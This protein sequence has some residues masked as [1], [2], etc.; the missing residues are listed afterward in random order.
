MQINRRNILLGSGALLVSHY[1]R[2]ADDETAVFW[3]VTPQGRKGAVLFGY[4]RIAPAVVADVI[5]DGDALVD[6][7][8]RVVLDMPPDVRFSTVGATRQQLKPIAQVVS[9]ATADRL[10]KFLSSTPAAAIGDRISGLETTMLLM[11]EGQHNS[12]VT[13]AG[14]IV[15][16]ARS[17]GKPIDQLVSEAEIQSAWQQPDFV[18][19]DNRIGEETVAYMLDLR[20]KVGPIGGYLEQLYRQRKAEEIERVTADMTSHGVVSPSQ[21]LETDKVRELMLARAL[22]MLTRQ[23]DEARFMTFPLGLLAGSSGLLAAFKAKGLTVV[24]RA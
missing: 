14:A 6:A 20:D 24:P 3:R 21:F 1:A 23:A 7:S 5:R 17:A 11:G 18:G 2:A 13:A 8:D 15:D 4:V 12:T 22:D 9:P 19:L 16:H 10:R